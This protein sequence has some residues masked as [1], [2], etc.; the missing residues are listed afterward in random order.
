M[1]DSK[2]GK[3]SYVT[4]GIKSQDNLLDVPELCQ[5]CE[6]K[7]KDENSESDLN[8]Y[9]C[10]FLE[11]DFKPDILCFTPKNEEEYSHLRDIA[12]DFMNKLEELTLDL[13]EAFYRDVRNIVEYVSKITRLCKVAKIQYTQSLSDF[14]H[15]LGKNNLKF[16]EKYFFPA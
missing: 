12:V 10:E 3:K 2:E 13:E 8:F 14:T 4:I 6:C 16:D 5:L 7:T 11:G 15:Y 9:Y 1:N